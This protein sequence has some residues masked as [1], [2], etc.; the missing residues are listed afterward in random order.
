MR[1]PSLFP[2]LCFLLSLSGDV[3]QTPKGECQEPEQGECGPRWP[4]AG[5]ASIHVLQKAKEKCLVW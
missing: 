1:W 4:K 5:P 2:G 3:A